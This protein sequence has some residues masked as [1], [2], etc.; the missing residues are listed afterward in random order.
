[1]HY[2]ADALSGF[3]RLLPA[4]KRHLDV[5]GLYYKNWVKSICRERA[6]PIPPDL[7]QG[8]AAAA[9]VQQKARLAISILLCFLG[10]LRVSELL[11][12]TVSDFSF[13]QPNLLHVT[14]RESKGSKRK[15]APEAVQVKDIQLIRAISCLCK[16][17]R[18]MK[19]CFLFHTTNSPKV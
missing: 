5:S 17:V 10:L 12:L 11:T 1:M 8:M 18:R 2:A 14:L 4:C 15:G 3:K 6:W 19:S 13:L 7:V 16:T 9:L